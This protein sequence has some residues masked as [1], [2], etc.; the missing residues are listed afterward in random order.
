MDFDFDQ[1]ENIA[2]D[3]AALVNKVNKF[4]TELC[5]ELD[6]MLIK[7]TVL[8]VRLSFASG[9][10]SLDI[11]S[12]PNNSIFDKLNIIKRLMCLNEDLVTRLSD[13]K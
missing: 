2:A 12:L 7:Q 13:K 4:T 6:A 3:T 1:F 10:A 11:N 9:E 8:N 5:G